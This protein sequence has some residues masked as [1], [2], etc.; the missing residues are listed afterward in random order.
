MEGRIEDTEMLTDYTQWKG[1]TKKKGQEGAQ[2]RRSRR[3]E[4][5]DNPEE[6]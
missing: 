6:A 2:E 4:A 5:A 1:H 3:Q